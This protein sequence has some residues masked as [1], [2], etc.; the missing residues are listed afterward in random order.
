MGT[1]RLASGLAL[2]GIYVLF[3]VSCN[4]GPIVDTPRPGSPGKAAAG[5]ELTLDPSTTSTLSG[6]VTLDGT[7][8]P[9]RLINMSADPAC[10]QMHPKPLSY[11][12]VV[13]GPNE[14]L[15]DV[16]IY[17]RSGLGNYHFEAPADAVRLNQQG[18]LYSPV[19]LALMVGQRLEL[20]NSDT[21]YHNVHS[22]SRI[23]ASWN[24]TDPPGVS[25]FKVFAQPE[26]AIPIVCNVHPWMHS[27][28]FVFDNPY[29]AVTDASGKFA[30]RN[31]PPGTY[32]IEAWHQR[33]GMLDQSLTVAPNTSPSIS[34]VYHAD[35][36]P[37]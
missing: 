30:W 13:T 20:H 36:A 17:I 37:H 9:P 26:F 22:I 35:S 14:G 32:K 4:P 33:Y 15:A 5:P 6:T 23:D 16:A 11:A 8:P 28:V 27:Y 2:V 34:F 7:P 24:E 12:D 19:V 29:F 31:L 3:V 18:C 10:Q 1:C 25:V 21:T